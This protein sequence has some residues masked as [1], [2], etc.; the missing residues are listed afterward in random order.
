[1]PGAP[2]S[3]KQSMSSSGSVASLS[4]MA[5]SILK[6]G[7][8]GRQM[9]CTSGPSFGTGARASRPKTAFWVFT[10]ATSPG[11]STVSPAIQFCTRLKN[12]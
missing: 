3:K 7:L 4:L 1:M 5:G 10:R 6:F 2:F 12:P 8:G 9:G 11:P